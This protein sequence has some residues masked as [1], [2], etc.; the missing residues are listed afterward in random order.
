MNDHQVK[1]GITFL[2]GAGLNLFA[3]LNC[4]ALPT[5]VTQSLLSAGAPLADYRR[6]VLVG[7]GGRLWAALQAWDMETADP[8]RHGR[9]NTPAKSAPYTT[10]PPAPPP[11]VC[12]EQSPRRPGRPLPAPCQ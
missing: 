5:A 9:S 3:V 11:L 7:H 12:P 8:I 2:A 6:L 1:R 4:A 10:P